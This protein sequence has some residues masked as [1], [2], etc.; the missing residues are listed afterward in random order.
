[1]LKRAIIKNAQPG[2]TE[3]PRDLDDSTAMAINKYETKSLKANA[4][5][6]LPG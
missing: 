3:I 4:E 2:P 5:A 6:L 1:M